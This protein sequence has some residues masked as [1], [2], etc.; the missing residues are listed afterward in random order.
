MAKNNCSDWWG[1]KHCDG[2]HYGDPTIQKPSLFTSREAARLYV[3]D[4]N[5]DMAICKVPESKWLKVTRYTL[6]ERI[7]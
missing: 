6:R 7:D 3:R 2:T 1:V 4:Y 5:R